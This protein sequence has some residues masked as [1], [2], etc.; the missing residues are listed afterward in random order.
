MQI[1]ADVKNGIPVITGKPF[2]GSQATVEGF[3]KSL[4]EHG[5]VTKNPLIVIGPMVTTIEYARAYAETILRVCDEIQPPLAESSGSYRVPEC[6]E[7]TMEMP[8]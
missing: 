6:E 5:C 2:P 4:D 3:T 1:L 8:F 7:H